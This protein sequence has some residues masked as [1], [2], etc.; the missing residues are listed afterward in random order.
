MGGT[1]FFQNF[2]I[3]RDFCGRENLGGKVKIT[4]FLWG[5]GSQPPRTLCCALS[6]L[7][8]TGEVSIGVHVCLSVSLSF[9][10]LIMMIH[11]YCNVIFTDQSWIIIMIVNPEVFIVSVW[12]NLILEIHSM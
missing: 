8:K 4:N 5:G 6:L 12:K 7:E 10:A 2:P 3:L 1:G 9:L 11:Y